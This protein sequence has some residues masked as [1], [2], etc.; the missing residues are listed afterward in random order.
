MWIYCQSSGC[1]TEDATPIARGYSGHGEGKNN[2][3]DQHLANVGPLPR[4]HYTISEA[5]THAAKGPLVMRLTPLPSTEMFHR[6]G[7]LIHGDSATHPGAA[8]EGC[9][10]L[11]HATRERIAAS[12]DRRLEVCL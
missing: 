2:P 5:F 8:S 9:I 1:L 3:E 7:F 10:I 6:S 11:D 4:G 12:S